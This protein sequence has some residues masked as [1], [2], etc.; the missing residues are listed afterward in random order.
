MAVQSRLAAISEQHSHRKAD[1]ERQ[2]TALSSQPTSSISA[3]RARRI[4]IPSAA[5]ITT[6]R[7]GGVCGQSFIAQHG[8]SGQLTGRGTLLPSVSFS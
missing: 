2:M 4:R 5:R 1:Q 7:G 6:L 8:L 3:A